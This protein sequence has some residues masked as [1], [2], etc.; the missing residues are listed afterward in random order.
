ML[1]CSTLFVSAQT[2]VYRVNKAST[3]T[4]DGLTWDSGFKTI[5]A[6]LAAAGDASPT[7][8]E[9]W[10]KADTYQEAHFWLR[11]NVH[12]FGGFLGTE[13]NRDDRNW[14]NNATI[15]KPSAAGQRII[16]RH[17]GTS[18]KNGVLDGFTLTGADGIWTAYLN[19]GNIV[20]NCT[21]KDNN[22]GTYNGGAIYLGSGSTL[23]NCVVK[24]NISG[25]SGGGVAG[26]HAQQKDMPIKIINCEIVNNVS[27]G[28]G[29]GVYIGSYTLEMY[30]TLIA[31]NTSGARGGGFRFETPP[32]QS[33]ITNCT[34]VNNESGSEKEG[35]MYLSTINGEV[36]YVTNTIMYGNRE[37]GGNVSNVNVNENVSI[38]Y[39]E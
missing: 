20:R 13:T 39:T 37:A 3:Q 34:V 35:G 8:I 16:I 2:T 23:E 10:V 27:T 38:S 25:G 6:A 24:D 5:G 32:Q 21:F 11:N 30:N 17:S 9:I 15:L 19:A 28:D 12:I 26:G 14:Q 4:E 18:V 22:S 7:V 29:G 1:V 36:V 31:N 33:K